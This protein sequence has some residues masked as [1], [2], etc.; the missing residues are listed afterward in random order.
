MKLAEVRAIAKSKGII[1]F[2]KT[3]EALVR[4]I[5]RTERNR[6][7]FNRGQSTSCGQA[8]CAWREDCR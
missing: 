7:C 5:Q 2:G 4:E 8:R 1:S 3:R 6:D